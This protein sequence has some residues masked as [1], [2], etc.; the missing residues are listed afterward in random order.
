VTTKTGRDLVALRFTT[1]RE[2]DPFRRKSDVSL[3]REKF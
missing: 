1:K 3:A 2:N